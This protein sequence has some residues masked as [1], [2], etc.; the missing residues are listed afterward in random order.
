MLV[1]VATTG[2]KP[3]RK[4]MRCVRSL[5][6]IYP[7]K[8]KQGLDETKTYRTV[9]GELDAKIGRP[10]PRNEQTRNNSRPSEPSASRKKP[11]DTTRKICC[12]KC[13]CLL[14]QNRTN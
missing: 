12:F 4:R 13:W 1:F 14:T 6:D 5:A 8:T 10:N 11:Q 3:E 7:T 2:K 9:P